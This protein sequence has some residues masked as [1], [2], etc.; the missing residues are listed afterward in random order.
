MNKMEDLDFADYLALLSSKFQDIQQKTQSLH[1]NASEVCL[2]INIS[3]TKVM[4]LNSNIK[5]QF[6]IDGK[7]IEDVDTFAYLGRQEIY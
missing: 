6:K 7:N 4:R 5:E 3:K 2:K 1:E